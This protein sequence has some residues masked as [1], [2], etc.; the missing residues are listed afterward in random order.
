MIRKVI[1]PLFLFCSLI[2]FAQTSITEVQG[3]QEASPFEG[4]TVTI[5]G[6]VTASKSGQGYFVQDGDSAWTGIFL[7]DKNRSPMPEIGDEVQLTGKVSEYFGLT[8][9]SDVSAFEI[10]S[11]GNSLPKP[12]QLSTGNVSE[13]YEGVLVK[14]TGASCSTVS[15]GYGEWEVDDSSGPLAIDDMFFAFTP[16]LGV[17][18]DV[19]G[20]VTF[21][22]EAYKIEPRSA[23]DIM[24][25]APVYFT[26]DPH[27][28]KLSKSAITVVWETNT[29]ATT[30]L[31]YGKTDALELGEIKIKELS[32]FHEITL[33]NLDAGELYYI[34]AYSIL[35]ADSS[36]T[37]IKSYT[38]ISNSSG[39]MRVSFT[40]PMYKI[41]T[42]ANG[43][44]VVNNGYTYSMADTIVS[45]INKAQNTLD[46]AIYD[47]VN[48]SPDSDKTNVKIFDAVKAKAASGVKVR[49]ITDDTSTDPFFTNLM[50][51]ANVMWGN[52]DAIMHH[53]FI[54][55]DAASEQGS[56]V[57]TGSV[58][59][60][61]NNLVMDAN[62]LISIQD[63]S[64]AKAYTAEFNEMWGGS[65]DAPNYSKGLFGSQKKDNTPHLFEIG[66]KNV[67][68]YFSPSDKTENKIIEAMETADHEIAFNMMAFTSDGLGATLLLA[69]KNGVS[70]KGVIDYVE[71]SGSEFDVL[72]NGGID[73]V[74]FANADGTSWPDGLT[75]HHKYAVVDYNHPESDPILITGTHN[76]SASADTR[77][78]ENTLIIHDA[79]LAKLYADEVDNVYL[80][81]NVTGVIELK[82]AGTKVF[83]NPASNQLFISSNSVISSY[84]IFSTLGQEITC[85]NG[86]EV[87]T[88]TID[89]SNFEKGIYLI[90]LTNNSGVIQTARFLKQ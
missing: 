51:N 30:E 39:E 9:I 50:A 8:E 49:V 32:N 23:N 59:W 84:T 69:N 60:T 61:Y 54:V 22:F 73:V 66:G 10:L 14:I 26:T 80:M 67:E 74:D 78:D 57:V 71:Y 75:I 36:P 1:L 5:K 31:V 37:V 89:L 11:S 16:T 52:T 82:D 46:I 35:G 72:L 83:P 76:W 77:N 63:R 13:A 17:K 43:G 48:H 38:T 25:Q 87:S 81:S 3:R 19:T 47:V 27:Q 65:Q 53:K 58:N 62:N 64:L 45:Y 12:I 28:I 20:P 56:W 70:V 18:Y 33:E 29:A 88:F 68:L 44:K 55:I 2:T 85:R 41:L 21:G 42:L 24:I 34:K 40:A 4:K 15:L 7:Y 86:L 6:I 90:K 79:K